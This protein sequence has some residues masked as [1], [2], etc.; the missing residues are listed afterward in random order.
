MVARFKINDPQYVNVLLRRDLPHAEVVLASEYDAL[1]TRIQV[2]ELIVIGAWRASCE[3]GHYFPKDWQTEVIAAMP[4]IME[5][6]P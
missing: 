5:Y 6:N 4:N 2:L 1:A 3:D